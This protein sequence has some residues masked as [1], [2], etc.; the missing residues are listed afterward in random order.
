M[1]S[2]VFLTGG[3]GFIGT[4]LLLELLSHNCNIRVLYKQPNDYVNMRCEVIYGDILH[5]KTF[6]S[7]LNGCDIL[8]HCAAYISFQK[9]DFQRAFQVNVQG[10]RNI[11][12]AAYH[13]EVKKVIH[14]SACAVLGFS[15]YSNIILDETTNPEINKENVYAYTKKLAEDEVQKYV[16]KG[17]NVSIANIA[18]VYGAGDRK[19]NSGS[20]IKSIYEGKMKIVPP[21]GT[22]YVSVDD[23]ISGLILLAEKGRP[24][25]RYIFCN[26]NLTYQELTQR[27]ARTLG[28]KEPRFVLPG[29]TYY[30][31]LCALHGLNF[32]SNFNKKQINLMT[33]QILK[34]SYGYKYFSSEKAQKELGWKPTQNLELAVEKAFNYYQKNQLI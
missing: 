1:K 18:T 13:A 6:I 21:G 8:F 30:P 34:E 22:S 23:L 20:I 2:K 32:F 24:G 25:E 29:F 9:N 10:T 27:I 33:P 11:L 19:L 4:N 16:Q 7:S 12:E 5:P 15:S 28:V 26:E 3:P 17:L 31:A 14:L